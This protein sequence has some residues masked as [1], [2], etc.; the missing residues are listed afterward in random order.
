MERLSAPT[1]GRS[2]QTEPSVR[3]SA[4]RAIGVLES[5]LRMVKEEA[6]NGRYWLADWVGE[7]RTTVLVLTRMATPEELPTEVAFPLCSQR[8]EGATLA[9]ASSMH[10]EHRGL[11]HAGWA[12]DSS[13]V[14]FRRKV[15]GLGRTVPREEHGLRWPDEVIIRTQLAPPK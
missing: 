13:K 4:C 10:T 15:R 6:K 7:G 3:A 9:I 8:M 1:H 12:T 2:V 11:T 14:S 5:A